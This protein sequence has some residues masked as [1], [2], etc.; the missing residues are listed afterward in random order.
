MNKFKKFLIN[1]IP[2]KKWRHAIRYWE[3]TV[4]YECLSPAFNVFF[5]NDNFKIDKDIITVCGIKFINT[6]NKL[7]TIEGLGECFGRK[8]YEFGGINNYIFID[9]GTNIGDS[10]LYAATSKNCQKIY[11][12]EPFPNQRS[13]AEKNFK[14]NPELSQKIELYNYGWGNKNEDLEIFSNNDLS[15]SRGNSVKNQEKNIADSNSQKI[16]VKIKNSSEELKRILS[17]TPPN[18]KLYL[19]WI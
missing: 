18:R 3:R 13:I 14:L 11:S 10:A 12:Y 4:K 9:L 7:G 19:K 2:V 16:I 17:I 1:I 8:D 6:N 15:L 5:D